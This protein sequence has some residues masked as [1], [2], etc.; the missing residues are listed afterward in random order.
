MDLPMREAGIDTWSL[1]WYLREGSPAARAMQALATQPVARGRVIPDEIAGHRVGW[2]PGSRLLFAEGH[3]VDDALAGCAELPV[4]AE[5]L[6]E[7]LGDLGIL[8]PRHALAPIQNGRGDLL[9]VIGGSGF[10]G[11]RRFDS[12]FNRGFVDGAEGVT[13]LAGVAAVAVPRLKTHVIERVGGGAV[14][15][16][17]H[18][19][20]GGKNVLD[21]IYDKGIQSGAAL[22]GQL[23]RFECQIRYSKESRP[24]LEAVCD[25]R[26][27]RGMFV[28][29]F[30][31]LWKASKGVTVGNTEKLAI[32]LGE[33]V[34]DGVLS[35]TEARSL[36]GHLALDS[37]GVEESRMQRRGYN[38][39]RERARKH[40]LVLSS[41]LDL[42]VDLSEVLESV[43]DAES[44]N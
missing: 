41:G 32:R 36:A 23:V 2:F 9:P 6:S 18:V 42:D 14:E 10:A 16:V 33:L 15:T 31:P 34:D 12:T 5:R 11:V 17:Y 4:A 38:K 24:P 3:P 28:H 37:V 1:G 19:G 44:W 20:S 40:G 13:V 27:V 43:F 22:R 29:R 39:Q 30:E 25:Q 26:Y 7:A 35:L 21:R 8:P